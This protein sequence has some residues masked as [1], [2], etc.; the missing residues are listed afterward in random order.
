MELVVS[1]LFLASK[2]SKGMTPIKAIQTLF[3]NEL[4]ELVVV[5]VDG[6]ILWTLLCQCCQ[7]HTKAMVQLWV[8]GS[9][10]GPRVRS[11]HGFT[12]LRCQSKHTYKGLQMLTNQL[13]SQV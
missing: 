10:P 7:S 3:L 4:D 12:T 13:I 8:G 6:L 5:R 1:C 11:K 2:K 9:W